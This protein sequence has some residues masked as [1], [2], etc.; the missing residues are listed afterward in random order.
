MIDPASL[1][2]D[3]RKF[4]RFLAFNK[5]YNGF[6]GR[7]VRYVIE[8][9]FQYMSPMDFIRVCIS[10]HSDTDPMAAHDISYQVLFKTPLT[11]SA[12]TSMLG[13]SLR[14]L[15]SSPDIHLLS[16]FPSLAV[17]GN[18]FCNPVHASSAHPSSL[19]HP[20]HGYV[21]PH[22]SGVV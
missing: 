7:M 21:W 6:A 19:T 14:K 10:N 9:D 13:D 20:T 1:D 15:S 22:S 3:T 5:S 4:D 17:L 16:F 12:Q 8:I 11:A 18:R 2:G